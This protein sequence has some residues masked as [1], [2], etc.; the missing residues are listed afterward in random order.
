[1]SYYVVLTSQFNVCPTD[2]FIIDSKTVCMLMLAKADAPM[3][4]KFCEFVTNRLDGVV[5][6]P[7]SA[8]TWASGTF[9]TTQLISNELC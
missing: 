3:I 9:T 4:T 5:S 7:S 6:M 1:M 2:V 8:G